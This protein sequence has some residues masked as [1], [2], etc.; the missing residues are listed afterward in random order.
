MVLSY[1]LE[2]Q[3]LLLIIVFQILLI[4]GAVWLLL[5]KQDQRDLPE[6]IADS[7]AISIS[8]MAIIAMLFFFGDQFFSGTLILS[9]FI[10]LDGITI[11]FLIKKRVLNWRN[12][13]WFAGTALVVL[14][15]IAFR[16]YQAKDLVFPAWVD[17]V[18][19]V[20]ITKKIIETGGL[21]LTLAPELNVPLYY[22][23][24]FHIV[25]ALFSGISRLEPA[26]AVLWLGQVINAL[27][28]LGIYR[29][30]KS[31]FKKV[32]PALLA[33]L[34]VGFAFQMPAYYVTWGRYTLLT[35]LA[36]GNGVC[37]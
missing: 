30:G 1:P 23:Y 2:Q 7:I 32:T 9:L 26:Q 6:K 18:H 37:F 3:F 28:V 8:L 36:T 4:P 17:S 22:H 33:A 29:L 21:P 12:L 15:V 14:L 24:G 31:I 27:V 13:A 25:A 16:F 19:H 35:G 20:L 11:F 5:F 10:L 34:L